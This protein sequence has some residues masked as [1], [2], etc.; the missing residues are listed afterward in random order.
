MLHR[1]AQKCREDIC[2]GLISTA[3][4]WESGEKCLGLLSFRRT[5]HEH[6]GMSSEGLTG[7]S[8][9]S[10][11]VATKSLNYCFLSSKESFHLHPVLLSSQVTDG[12]ITTM[13][14]SVG[15]P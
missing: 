9:I 3:G 1:I 11:Y 14:L 8:L 10:T 6:S 12:T 15:P 13:A 5:S 7:L 2:S 4:D